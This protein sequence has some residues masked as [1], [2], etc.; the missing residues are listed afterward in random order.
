M[1]RNKFKVAAVS[2]KETL[3]GNST[4]YFLTMLVS[5]GKKT[6]IK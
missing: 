2:I 6:N 1:F 3:N 4:I 5:S